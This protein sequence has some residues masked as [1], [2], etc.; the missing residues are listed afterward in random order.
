MR[1]A[2]WF[3]AAWLLLAPLA[4]LADAASE[5]RAA[6]LAVIDRPRAALKPELAEMPAVDGL[7]KY[8]LWFFADASERVPGYLLL[9]DARIFKGP[10]PVVIAL[11]GTGGNKDNSQI[12]ELALKAARAGFIGVAIDGRFHGERITGRSGTVEYNAAMTH[13]FKTGQGHPFF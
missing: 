6:Y 9:P 4:A 5:T 11:H 12:A 7:R 2:G 1:R 10:R 13:A 3:A 8:H